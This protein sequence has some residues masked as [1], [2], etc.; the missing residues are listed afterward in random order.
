MASWASNRHWGEWEDWT[1]ALP[2][3][4]SRGVGGIA[5]LDAEGVAGALPRPP[6]EAEH[7]YEPEAQGGGMTRAMSGTAGDDIGRTACRLAEDISGPMPRPPKEKEHVGDGVIL[8]QVGHHTV[9]ST[10]VDAVAVEGEADTRAGAD[11]TAAQD[12]GEPVVSL[13]GLAPID[14]AVRGHD[15]QLGGAV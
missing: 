3:A 5:C 9:V 13:L 8:P 7:K 4:I 15:T 6:K 14:A 10:T 12:G 2:G 11:G 1:R